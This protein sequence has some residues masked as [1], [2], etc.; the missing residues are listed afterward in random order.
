MTPRTFLS[1]LERG[2]MQRPIFY[3]GALLD[4]SKIGVNRRGIRTPFLG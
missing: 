3:D 2:S 1:P 4:P